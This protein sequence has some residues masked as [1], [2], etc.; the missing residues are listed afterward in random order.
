MGLGTGFGI[1][2]GMVWDGVWGQVGTGSRQGS[3][4]SPNKKKCNISLHKQLHFDCVI[5]T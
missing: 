3:Y 4:L 2:F 1:G 5:C